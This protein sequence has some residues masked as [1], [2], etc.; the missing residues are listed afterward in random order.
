MQKIDPEVL[1]QEMVQL[2]RWRKFEQT[3]E[4]PDYDME[5]DEDIEE[6]VEKEGALDKPH[7]GTW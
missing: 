4:A 6:I 1:K 2:R 3:G 7:D 5:S